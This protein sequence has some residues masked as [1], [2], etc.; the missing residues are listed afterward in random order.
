LGTITA[1]LL[2][3]CFR[4]ALAANFAIRSSSPITENEVL[5]PPPRSLTDE[6]PQLT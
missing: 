1:T 3:F 2:K 5:P 4:R 6:L